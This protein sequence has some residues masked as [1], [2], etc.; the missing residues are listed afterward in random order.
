MLTPTAVDFSPGTELFPQTSGGYKGLWFRMRS[1]RGSVTFHE[2]GY[3]VLD[4]LVGLTKRRPPSLAGKV[5]NSRLVTGRGPS[6]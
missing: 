1:H 4:R 5:N 2:A 3:S 6:S